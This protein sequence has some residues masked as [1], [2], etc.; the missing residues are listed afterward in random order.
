MKR[1]PSSDSFYIMPLFGVLGLAG[2]MLAP[3]ARAEDTGGWY[4]GANIGEGRNAY[5]TSYPD[6]QY[7]AAAVAAGDTL[8]FSSSSAHR[9]QDAWWV[10]GGYLPWQFFGLEAAFFRLPEL[11]HRAN[12]TLDT[13]SGNEPVVTTATVT[14][15][16]PA[17]SLVGRL[18]LT[19]AFEADFRIG[20]Y[21]GKSALKAGLLLNSTYSVTSLSSSHSSLL[22]A[23][24]GAYTVAGHWSVRLDLLHFN[25][26]G[27]S[28]GVG[29]FNV[30]LATA[31]VSYTF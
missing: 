31:G 2:V 29:Q 25:K 5:D 30:D 6:D 16:G 4:L 7:R 23:V 21:L 12:A 14:S 17:L 15:H 11:T 19:D 20:D 9:Y 10:N 1:A 26:V 27:N 24:G 22:V 13:P 28:G 8:A 3:A 18:P